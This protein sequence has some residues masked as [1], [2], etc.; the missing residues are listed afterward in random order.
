MV[1]CTL[2]ILLSPRNPNH[3]YYMILYYICPAVTPLHKKG[4]TLIFQE[5][6]LSPRN[7]N[8]IYCMLSAE[9]LRLERVRTPSNLSSIH[10]PAASKPLLRFHQS[11]IH[12][13]ADRMPPK[14]R[15]LYI[16]ESIRPPQ[17]ATGRHRPPQ[18][19]KLSGFGCFPNP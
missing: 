10:H 3:V 2:N 19:I 16:G 12:H 5:E 14:S 1:H 13:P 8:H 18:G 15:N 7:P 11:C 4:S 9:L 17:A 6:T